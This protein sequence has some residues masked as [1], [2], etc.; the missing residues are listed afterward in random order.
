MAANVTDREDYPLCELG[1][2]FPL[3][4]ETNIAQ[5][6]RIIMYFVGLLWSFIG[7]AIVADIF[8]CAIEGR[9]SLN[10]HATLTDLRCPF[11]S[12]L[13]LNAN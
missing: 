8:M 13:T 9:H 2:I 12:Y 5:P 1:M 4:D 6:V 10:P 7:V 11:L 3:I